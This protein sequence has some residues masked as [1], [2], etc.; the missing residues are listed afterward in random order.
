M[1]AARARLIAAFAMMA[2]WQALASSGLL[3]RDVVPS[4]WKIAASIAATLTDPAFYANL[5]VTGLEFA[6]AV[7]LGGAAGIVIGLALGTNRFLSA[8]YERWVHYLA[9][10]PKIIFFP[11]LLLLFG[12]GPGSKIAMGAL[13]CGFIVAISVADGVRGIPS[14]LIQV[15][16]SF[17]ANIWQMA[18]SIYL[19]AI[20]EP[21]LNGIRLG[22][23]VAAI[24]VLLA[25][26]KLSKA[27]LGFMVM[28]AYR[29]FDMP[30]MYALLI[31]VVL[32]VATIN[33]AL[34][35]LRAASA[36]SASA[37]R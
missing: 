17:R 2:A 14:V 37:R 4:L 31:L 33:A 23:G 1:A 24:G 34:M 9:P 26:T 7:L 6:A 12:A 11:V 16:R 22:F 3:F 18:V 15:G 32:L 35:R 8:A 25:E 13:S 28:D 21:L 30:S 19:P 5:E 27:G 10:T 29:R 20:R 36:I